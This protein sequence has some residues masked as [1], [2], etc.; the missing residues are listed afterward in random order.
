MESSHLD[1]LEDGSR[2]RYIHTVDRR[3]MLDGIAVGDECTPRLQ[4]SE[5]SH[6]SFDLGS[7]S[8]NQDRICRKHGHL[9]ASKDL[10]GIE[11]RR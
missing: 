3:Q 11:G 1:L 10:R 5:I 9:A 7:A 6:G 8:P 2:D 4:T